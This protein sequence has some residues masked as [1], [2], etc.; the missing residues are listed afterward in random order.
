[1][2]KFRLNHPLLFVLFTAFL[3]MQWTA[4]LG[5]HV[6]LGE[7]H[8]HDGS[9]HQHNIEVHVHNAINHHADTIDS[10][11]QLVD[12]DFVNIDQDCN[13]SNVKYQQQSFLTAVEAGF[14]YFLQ[15]I[16]NHSKYTALDNS[17]ASYLSLSIINLRAPPKFS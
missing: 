9:Q 7:H 12:I 17:K 5:S 10:S 16:S 2:L 1:M 14:L 13:S 3:T 6:H 4:V 15:F 8:D 11:H